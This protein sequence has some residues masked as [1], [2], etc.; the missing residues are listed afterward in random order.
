MEIKIV[1]LAE[2][3]EYLDEVSE[4]FWHVWG[5][6]QTLENMHYTTVHTTQRD[7]VP[8]TYIALSGERR[9]GTVSLWMHDLR[10]RQ[11]L[12]PWLT[13]LYVRE[14]IQD[15][16]VDKLLQ[17]QMMV[18]ALQLGYKDVFTISTTD[19]EYFEKTGWTFK[20]LAPMNNGVMTRIYHKDLNVE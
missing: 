3:L 12:F 10:C 7:K 15:Q 13:N 8:L 2:R 14:D 18:E 19:Y 5:G 17:D 9:V 20:E 1:N 11:D 16:G 4:W 6:G